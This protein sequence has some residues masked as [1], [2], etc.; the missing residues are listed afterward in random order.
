[1]HSFV[2]SVIHSFIHSFIQLFIHSFVRSFNQSIIHSFIHSITHGVPLGSGTYNTILNASLHEFLSWQQ[3]IPTVL[4][5]D[6]VQ[7]SLQQLRPVYSPPAFCAYLS[8]CLSICVSPAAPPFWCPRICLSVCVPTCLSVSQSLT[9]CP[10]SVPMASFE[11][12]PGR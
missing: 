10:V 4:R 12:P 6:V 7:V 3:G 9:L 5:P 11:D 2:R 1:V 8:V